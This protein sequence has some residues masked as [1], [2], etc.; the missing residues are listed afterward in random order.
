MTFFFIS[1]GHKTVVKWGKVIY[2]SHYLGSLSSLPRPTLSSCE[3]STV[4]D[5]KVK[6]SLIN[7]LTVYQLKHSFVPVN[8]HYTYEAC[9]LFVTEE[10]LQ[11]MKTTDLRGQTY[12]KKHKYDTSVTFSTSFL[13]L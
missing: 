4:E 6:G 5:M 9:D 12:I 7:C 8:F 1:L 11:L 13:F 3:N 2:P 10:K